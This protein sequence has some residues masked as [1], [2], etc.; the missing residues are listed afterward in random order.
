MVG[1]KS[2]SYSNLGR[3][4][5]EYSMPFFC[6]HHSP[7]QNWESSFWDTQLNPK[8]CQIYQDFYIIT[9]AKEVMFLLGF[10][11]LSVCEQ[12]NSKTYGRILIKFSGYVR[13][14]KRKK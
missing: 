7:S 8:K 10:V 9:S 11:C 5:G 13:N 6:T 12:D 2:R 14:G 1:T 3:L 4:E